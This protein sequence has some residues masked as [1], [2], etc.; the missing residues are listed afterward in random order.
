ME[1][2]LDRPRSPPPFDDEP[3]NLQ[4]TPG[5]LEQLCLTIYGIWEAFCAWIQGPAGASAEEPVIARPCQQIERITTVEGRGHKTQQQACGL[6]PPIWIKILGMLSTQDFI[7]TRPTCKA[8]AFT[9]RELVN[10]THRIHVP[11]LEGNA[12]ALVLSAKNLKTLHC[13]YTPSFLSDDLVQKLNNHPNLQNI[14]DEGNADFS[15]RLLNL[16]RLQNIRLVGSLSTEDAS[17]LALHPGIEQIICQFTSADFLQ[18]REMNLGTW[19]ALKKV[20]NL[21]ELQISGVSFCSL[22]KEVF[23]NWENSKL[24]TLILHAPVFMEP[25]TL[26]LLADCNKLTTLSLLFPGDPE[27]ITSVGMCRQLER[28]ALGIE[29]RSFKDLDALRHC[30]RLNYLHVHFNHDYHTDNLETEISTLVSHLPQLRQFRLSADR[31]EYAHDQSRE[32]RL[33]QRFPNL[34]VTFGVREDLCRLNLVR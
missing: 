10:L 15:S 19:D 22:P 32:K 29:T 20:P 8:I 14:R 23:Q 26:P 21:R 3:E 11:S 13:D 24:E 33:K 4:E 30:T 2:H 12:I 5:C 1:I 17:K 18:G 28:L 16:R 34:E 27:L 9:H 6:P 31:F 25:P 7:R